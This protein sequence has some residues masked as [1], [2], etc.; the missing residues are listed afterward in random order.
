M[1]M[2]PWSPDDDEPSLSRDVLNAAIKQYYAMEGEHLPGCICS[3]CLYMTLEA[4]VAALELKV[5]QLRFDIYAVIDDDAMAPGG[6]YDD[7]D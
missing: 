3:V 6:S 2:Y 7:R 4:R 1:K 5:K